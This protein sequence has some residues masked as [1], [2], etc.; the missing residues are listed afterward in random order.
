MLRLIIEKELRDITGDTRFV[1]SF[2]VCSLLI[3][4]AFYGGERM[5]RS[6][7]ARYEASKR[8]NLRTLEGITDWKEVQQTRI[9]LPPQPLASL[10]TGISN[11]IGQTAVIQ[12]RGSVGTS[13]S[14]YGDDPV[15]AVFRFLDLDFIFQI[16][17]TLFA[18][19]LAYDSISGEKERGTL[20]LTFANGVRRSTYLT[21]KILGTSLAIGIPL[22]IPFLIGILIFTGSG[23]QLSGDEW[24][25]LVLIIGAG[26][27]LFGFFITLSVFVSALTRRSSSSFL[28]LLLF[29]VAFGLV[30]P[31]ISALTMGSL[32]D[33]PTTEYLESLK[34][35]FSGQIW[36][37]DKRAMENYKPPETQDM[38][39][40]MKDFNKFMGDLAS[41]REKKLNEYMSKLE[42]DRENRVERQTFLSLGL[43]RVSPV[44]AF[45]LAVSTLAGTSLSMKEA[46]LKQ[47]ESYQ[48]SYANFMVE[49]T[50]TN[51]SG[52]GFV[53]RMRTEDTEK[54]KPIDA[55]EMPQFTFTPRRL[56]DDAAS[57]IPDFGI[58]LTGII[59][60]F[61]GSFVAFL[62]YDV[63]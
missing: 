1:L 51:L 48:K 4:T 27:L 63:R 19:L 13:D 59:L 42:A 36:N 21:G 7:L 26:F 30:I 39:V 46:F 16:V 33:V 58:L 45:S 47:A 3:I 25:R 43:A 17:L 31:R 14:R 44:S 11:D 20:R 34:A 62:R 54:A 56:A 49:K 29:W 22:V 10:V 23:I 2:L 41:A 50:G 55:G 28:V 15:F 52:G 35:R 12:G 18:I 6:N 38:Q 61:A 53:I 40:M 60:C 57:L 9:F 32:V 37:D 8:E 5:Y 24:V